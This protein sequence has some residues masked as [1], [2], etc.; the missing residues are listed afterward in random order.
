MS[1]N[2]LRRI[3]NIPI[4]LFYQNHNFH[5]EERF[6]FHLFYNAILVVIFYDIKDAVSPG[7]LSTERS[8]VSLVNVSASTCI[9]S[10]A[11]IED[12]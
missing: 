9:V 12:V 2:F 4:L 7:F 10:K 5:L 11:S 3:F 1:T 6:I 8:K